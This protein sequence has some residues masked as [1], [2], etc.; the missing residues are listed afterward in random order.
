MELNQGVFNYAS[1]SRT[2][3]AVR[4]TSHLTHEGRAGGN[5]SRHE[6]AATMRRGRPVHPF[7]VART[8]II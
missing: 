5:F 1:P 4:A 7:G 2:Y 3:W 6:R 8:G